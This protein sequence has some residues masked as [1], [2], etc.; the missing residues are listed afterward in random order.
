M[1]VFIMNPP[2]IQHYPDGDLI[3]YY[4][5]GPT[6]WK[7]K[8]GPPQVLNP[9][10]APSQPFRPSAH[11]SGTC[12]SLGKETCDELEAE[13]FTFESAD[14]ALEALEDELEFPRGSL[15]KGP[16]RDTED[17]CPGEGRHYDVFD[18]DGFKWGS[19]FGCPCCIDTPSGPTG[20]WRWTF[21]AHR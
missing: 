6:V 3:H 7:P 2:D 16:K 1:H 5:N 13:G 19:V 12:A 10:P 21:N 4:P 18:D 9:K 15:H 8:D 11:E 20:S 17:Y 14:D